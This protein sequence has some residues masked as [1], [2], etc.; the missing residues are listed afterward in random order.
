[1]A[2]PTA[3]G[4]IGVGAS[5]AGSIIGAQGALQQG[6]AQSQMYQY[7]AGVAQLNS[8]IALQNADYARMQ[9][10]TQAQTIGIKGAQVGG[11]IRANQG[12]S[13]LDV[14]SGS[15]ADVQA[16]QHK[17]TEIDM[18]QAR[19]NAAKTAYDFDVQSTQDVAQA[20]LYG[21]AS[22][23]AITAGN[24]SAEASIVSGVSSVSSK[25]LAGNQQGLWGGSSGGGG[26]GSSSGSNSFS[27]VG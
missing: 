17:A 1:M 11:Q 15:N 26:G 10:E 14:N 20:G 8:Q 2:S 4:G 12:A 23:N 9:G 16:S 25:W 7:Q 22:T 27:A 5:I 6:Q 24:I 18:N 19:S 3:V 13:G 21:M